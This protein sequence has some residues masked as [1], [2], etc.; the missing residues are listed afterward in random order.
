MYYEKAISI[1]PNYKAAYINLGV[2]IL[3]GEN[4]IIEK[5]NNLGMSNE[6]DKEYDRLKEKRHSIYREAIPYL[7]KAH[8]LGGSGETK[9]TLNNI[10]ENLGMD[11]RVY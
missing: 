6:D 7:E 5:M 8:Q 3:D 2:L 1:D 11:K 4:Y 10:Y 9:A